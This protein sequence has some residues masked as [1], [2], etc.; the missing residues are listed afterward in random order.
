MTNLWRLLRNRCVC[1]RKFY[2]R[3]S[4][5]SGRWRRWK[6]REVW[7][8]IPETRRPRAANVFNPAQLREDIRGGGKLR[9]QG[10]FVEP[11]SDLPI[12]PQRARSQESPITNWLSPR[13]ILASG[14]MLADQ[15]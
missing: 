13:R 8:A 10:N 11:L 14:S 6:R 3:T 1:A 2:N 5:R 9:P 7:R 15:C 12:L 4:A